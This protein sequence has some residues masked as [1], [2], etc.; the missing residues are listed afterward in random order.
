MK[1]VI[2][3]M[4]KTII[5]H[6]DSYG[7]YYS[8]VDNSENLKHFGKLGQKWGIRRYQNP[9]GS[10]TPEGRKHYGVGEA[11]KVGIVEKVRNAGIKKVAGQEKLDKQLDYERKRRAKNS[12]E[13]ALKRD[14]RDIPDNSKASASDLM[15][16][17]RDKGS[18]EAIDIFV[19]ELAK[20]DLTKIINQDFIRG[21]GNPKNID[22]IVD[23][24]VNGTDKYL[25]YKE[26]LEGKYNVQKSEAERT[27]QGWLRDFKGDKKELKKW[28]EAVS[29]DKID[30]MTVIN[31]DEKKNLKDM[32]D[33]EDFG[34][35]W[36]QFTKADDDQFKKEMEELKKN[37]EEHNKN[38]K[39][40]IS[41]AKKEA[42]I[43]DI[44][45]L[46]ELA[47]MQYK[48]GGSKEEYEKTIKQLHERESNIVGVKSDKFY[49]DMIDSDYSEYEDY[50]KEHG[51]TKDHPMFQF[52]KVR[53][54]LIDELDPTHEQVNFQSD[55]IHRNDGEK[56]IVDG[57]EFRTLED[58][59]EQ[60]SYGL[61]KY[62]NEDI[63]AA[64]SKI[65]S[66]RK[67]YMKDGKWY[68][69]GEHYPDFTDVVKA[70]LDSNEKTFGKNDSDRLRQKNISRAESLHKS[71]KSPEEIAKILGIPLGTVNSYL[72]K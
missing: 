58:A 47:E 8:F 15:V 53:D 65:N 22:S 14:I 35:F 28:M 25:D 42:E 10:L 59:A 18:K 68:Y 26:Y 3:I 17:I 5:Q 70:M 52:Y 54:Q 30:Q 33:K 11:R 48:S 23:Q 39:P 66:N 32:L 44:I 71:G 56:W 72:Y 31:A 4:G 12:V 46:R 41:G 16:N 37:L 63:K 19:K 60:K 45:E 20:E 62:S 67:K 51:I 29:K 21:K 64:G 38:Y 36:M 27:K 61:T 69:K 6:S 43:N 50:Y 49:Q 2:D 9:D 34:N 57:K 55:G 7:Q 1:K 24:L 13:K 40:P